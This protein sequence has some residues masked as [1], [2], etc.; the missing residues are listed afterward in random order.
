[1][2]LCQSAAQSDVVR[3]SVTQQ[4]PAPAHQMSIILSCARV[5]SILRCAQLMMHCLQN[6]AH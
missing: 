4:Y 6:C 3:V 2:C 5:F 1:M